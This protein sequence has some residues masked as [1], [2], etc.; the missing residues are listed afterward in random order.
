MTGI[1]GSTWTPRFLS[2]SFKVLFGPSKYWMESSICDNLE[3]QKRCS[4][5]LFFL[6]CGSQFVPATNLQPSFNDEQ[7]GQV[8]QLMRGV[9]WCGDP[10]PHLC[11]A[12]APLHHVLPPSTIISTSQLSYPTSQPSYPSYLSFEVFPSQNLDDRKE[13]HQLT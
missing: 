10:I 4:K 9:K 3:H 2:W 8:G 12:P 5:V 13:N 6:G 7:S 11:V 1:L